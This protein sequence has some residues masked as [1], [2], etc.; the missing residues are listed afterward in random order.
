MTFPFMI[1]V[2]QLFNQSVGE[3]EKCRFFTCQ[4]R[5][6]PVLKVDNGRWGAHLPARGSGGAPLASPVGCE[7]EPQ[8]TTKGS[9]G[10]L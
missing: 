1:T 10:A 3:V 7:A 9:V 2:K 8:N 5:S 4:L 6:A